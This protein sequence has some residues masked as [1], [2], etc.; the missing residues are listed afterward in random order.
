MYIITSVYLYNFTYS[1]IRCF[2]LLLYFLFL[3]FLLFLLVYLFCCLFPHSFALCVGTL[4]I[5]IL[6]FLNN[7]EVQLMIFFVCV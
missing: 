2:V 4:S 7:Y 1:N 5:S 3:L 6:F